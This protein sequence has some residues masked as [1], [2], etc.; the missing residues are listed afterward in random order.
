M[1][2][3]SGPAAVTPASF[4]GQ[5]DI[6]REPLFASGRWEG[7]KSRGGARK[8]AQPVD[9]GLTRKGVVLFRDEIG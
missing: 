4:K 7:Y 9:L 1:K 5:L 2:A 3:G 8:P 6:M